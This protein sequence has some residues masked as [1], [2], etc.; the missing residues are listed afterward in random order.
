MGLSPTSSVSLSGDAQQWKMEEIILLHERK[1]RQRE[2]RSLPHSTHS[3]KSYKQTAIS[4]CHR[5]LHT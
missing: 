1:G 5:E 3:W 2:K 4:I